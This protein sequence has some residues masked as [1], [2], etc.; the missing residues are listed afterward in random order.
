VSLAVDDLRYVE[1][2]Q[3]KYETAGRLTYG[4]MRRFVGTPID[5]AE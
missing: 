5:V 2:P 1:R 4:T 3:Q